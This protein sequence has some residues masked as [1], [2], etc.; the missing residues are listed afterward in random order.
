MGRVAEIVR[1]GRAVS[2]RGI[3]AHWRPSD[4]R[5]IMIAEEKE[6]P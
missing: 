3:R 5:A 1:P 6:V 4:G 2:D